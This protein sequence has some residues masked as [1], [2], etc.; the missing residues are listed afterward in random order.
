MCP[1]KGCLD[2][3]AIL[4]FLKE[5]TWTIINKLKGQLH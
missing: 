3:P 5:A 2:L 1:F 4:C